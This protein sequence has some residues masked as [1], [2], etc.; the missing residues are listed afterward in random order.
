MTFNDRHLVKLDVF[1]NTPIP[2]FALW[3]DI[4]LD[5]LF[6]SEELIGEVLTSS[7]PDFNIADWK[8]LSPA[9]TAGY[10][11]QAKLNDDVFIHGP[12]N[13]PFSVNT[14]RMIHWL[15]YVVMKGDCKVMSDYYGAPLQEVN[16][17]FLSHSMPQDLATLYNAHIITD[18]PKDIRSTTLV[19]FKLH[20]EDR[21]SV[22]GDNYGFSRMRLTAT[23]ETGE[24]FVLWDKT[25][26]NPVIRFNKQISIDP[27]KSFDGTPI[28]AGPYS[29]ALEAYT[30]YGG[31]RSVWGYVPD[32]GDRK[33][34]QQWVILAGGQDSGEPPTVTEHKIEGTDSHGTIFQW[35]LQRLPRTDGKVTI[36]IPFG[37]FYHVLTVV[38]A[39][40]NNFLTMAGVWPNCAKQHGGLQSY[41]IGNIATRK[42]LPDGRQQYTI[43]ANGDW[44]H[45]NPWCDTEGINPNIAVCS[46]CGHV[47]ETST[48]AR[49]LKSPWSAG[50]TVI[51]STDGNGGVAEPIVTPIPTVTKTPTPIVTAIRTITPTAIPT[52]PACPTA[53]PTIVCPTVIPTIKVPTSVRRKK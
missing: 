51:G 53:I 45:H 23:S 17:S 48:A 13:K 47:L 1:L 8:Q 15:Q 12:T 5:G 9:F 39:G 20:E 2:K 7:I 24:Q 25:F 14:Q 10:Y 43:K 21:A 22:A 28:P 52:I 33:Y 30:P 26:N 44:F 35:D 27:T 34:L 42:Q 11:N 3:A 18:M 6:T 38:T 29:M 37:T 49:V 16:P 4:N 32:L 36:N 46:N 41:L 40:A 19:T 31:S 50:T